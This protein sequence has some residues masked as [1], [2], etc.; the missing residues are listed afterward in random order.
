MA[1]LLLI[2]LLSSAAAAMK[3]LKR[4]APMKNYAALEVRG[5]GTPTAGAAPWHQEKAFQRVRSVRLA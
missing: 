3:P 2:A 1:K 4:T 5:G